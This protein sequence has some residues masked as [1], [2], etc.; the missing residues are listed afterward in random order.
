ME[1]ID[2]VVLAAGRL[3]AGSTNRAKQ[4]YKGFVRVG[5]T[6]PLEA[7]LAAL[8]QTAPVAEI[9]V[10]GPLALRSSVTGFDRWLP[11]KKAGEDNVV[12]GLREAQTPRVL[13]CASDIPFVRAQDVA[14]F[15]DL[16]TPDCAVA[17]PIFER[18]EFLA[19]FPGGRDKFARLGPEEWT[20]GSLCIV[21]RAVVLRNEA[22][23]R[24]AF[25][26]RRSQL[27]MASLLGP[28]VLLK[29]LSGGLRVEDVIGRV[30]R[31]LG[32]KAAAVRGSSPRLAMDCDSAEDIE[33]ARAL[34]AR[35]G[36]VA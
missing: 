27:A 17:F 1:K 32:A 35:G 29:H 23:M 34:A 18:T 19:H 31:L 13:L 22:L 10:V 3:S 4:E 24:H 33:Y 9:I 6:T 12:A 30:S 25:Q 15:L 28:S 26:A 20:G 36:P 21:D 2:A 8:R 16:A 14:G 5:E 11:E 7:M